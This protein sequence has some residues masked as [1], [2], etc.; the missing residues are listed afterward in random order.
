[1]EY[2]THVHNMIERGEIEL[3]GVPKGEDPEG[4]YIVSLKVK[5]VPRFNLV[6]TIDDMT[7][8]GDTILEYKT[9]RVLWSRQ[10][11]EAHGQLF[12]YALLRRLATGTTPSRALLVSLETAVDEDAGIYLTGER[13]V[14]EVKITELD[15][16]KIQARFIAAYKKVLAYRMDI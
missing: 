3:P 7:D 8:D 6:G 5:N 11:A 12:A 15:I 13:R 4:T 10:K 2:G 16:L 14:I 1:M 9:A